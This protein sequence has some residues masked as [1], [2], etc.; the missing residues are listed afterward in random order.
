MLRVLGSCAFS[1]SL[2]PYQTPAFTRNEREA[3]GL[4][5]VV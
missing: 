3:R 2:D 1:R 4:R 5:Q